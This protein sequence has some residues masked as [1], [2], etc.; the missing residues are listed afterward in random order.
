MALL[1]HRQTLAWVTWNPYPVGYDKGIRLESIH[2]CWPRMCTR[3]VEPNSPSAIVS[4]VGNSPSDVTNAVSTAEAPPFN[5]EGER[6][7]NEY[8]EVGSLMGKPSG[9]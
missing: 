7:R 2:T 1:A 4:G 5:S 3:I 6:A 8:R 9:W